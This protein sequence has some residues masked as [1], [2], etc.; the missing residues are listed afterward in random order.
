M[1][2]SPDA[3]EYVIKPCGIYRKMFYRRMRT[4]PRHAPRFVW[5]M[6]RVFTKRLTSM[7]RCQA[8]HSVA[9]PGMLRPPPH[10]YAGYSGPWFEEQFYK[11]WSDEP[12]IG[13]AKYLPV[14]WH[15]VYSHI[16]VGKY[17]PN[18]HSRILRAMEVVL[19]QCVRSN[20]PFF[21]L[22]DYDHAPWD[23]HQFPKNVVV[24]GAGG[25][26]DLAIPLFKGAEQWALHP[27]DI[28][29]S[30]MGRLDGASDA[31]QVRSKMYAALKDVAHFGCGP[32]WR[33]VMAR[34][35]FT[36]C[37]R[38]LGRASFRMYEALAAGSIPVYIWDDREWL[39]FAD[40]LPWADMIIS[41]NVADL[42]GLSD[43]IRKTSPEE[44]ASR[45]AKIVA[46]YD[47]YLTPQGAAR[48][49]RRRMARIRTKDDALAL[50][51]ERHKS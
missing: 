21:T 9:S 5:H 28:L 24:L 15:Y 13:G 8:P 48:Q 16:Q 2:L 38:G 17:T 18:A 19:D 22:T 49:I 12:N 29:V 6:L 40:E 44:I 33:E 34:S 32:N 20:E 31:N 36:L 35:T 51:N 46:V 42:N 4:D 26:G 27:K 3:T 25:D 37:P 45:L 30:F 7:G 14:F 41:V 50:T 39:P 10:S 43:R 23:W 47:D 11:F 1:S